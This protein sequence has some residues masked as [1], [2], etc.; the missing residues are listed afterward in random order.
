LQTLHGE[1]IPYHE[2]LEIFYGIKLV[3]VKMQRERFVGRP[4][5]TSLKTL[6][7]VHSLSIKHIAFH[8][9]TPST[10]VLEGVELLK[11]FSAVTDLCYAH[12]DAETSSVG[13]VR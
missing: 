1:K 3:V 6:G 13:L 10:H 5:P 4:L 7:Y 11:L 8:S 9:A 2:A 12:F